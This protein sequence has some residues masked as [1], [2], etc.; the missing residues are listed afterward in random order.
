MPLKGCNMKALYPSP[1][2]RVMG[3]ADIL[4][5]V[6]QYDRIRP[7]IQSLGF[8]EYGDIFYEEGIPH[9]MMKKLVIILLLM[10]TGA[11]A[12]VRFFSSPPLP[13]P[14]SSQ[15]ACAEQCLNLRVFPIS[16]QSASAPTTPQT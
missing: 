14:V 6:E 15:A 4:I 5:R 8:E 16:V 12:Q 2:L 7:I 13:V 9:I 10:A 3:D 1:E 11:T